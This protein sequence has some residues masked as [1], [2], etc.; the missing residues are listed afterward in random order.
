LDT[1]IRMT[2]A[3][4][5]HRDSLVLYKS[6]PGR[7]LSLGGKKLELEMGG[8][9]TLSV[10]PKDVVL[11]HRGPLGNLDELAPQSG[12]TETAWEL[13][14]GTTTNLAELAELAYGE[15]TPAS[16]WAAWQLVVEGL[17]FSGSPAKIEAHSREVVASEREDR[18]AKAAEEVAWRAFTERVGEGYF[19]PEDSSFLED[20][21]GLA[22]GEYEQSRVLRALG[23]E[24]SQ[25]VAHAL[26][27]GVGYWD[28]AINPYPSR[29]GLSTASPTAELP[30]LLDEE[31]IDLTHLTALAIDD[32]GSQDPDDALSFEDGRLWVHIA[33]AAALVPPGSPADV[34]ARSRGASLYLP[35]GTV[36]M[37][38]RLATQRLGLGLSE[39]SPA[40]S[41]SFSVDSGGVLSDLE[42]APG[43]IRV[44]RLTYEEADGQ[45]ET[46][47]LRELYNLSQIYEERRRRNGAIMIDMPEVKVWLSEG[48]VHIRPLPA[49]RSRALVRE[50]MLMAG[51]SLARYALEHEIPFAFSSQALPPDELPPANSLSEMYAL[52]R[53]LKPSR[54]SSRPGPH[55]GLGLE[56]YAQA[57]SPLRRYLDLVAHQQ[58]RAHLRGEKM[59]E[60]QAITERVGATSAVAGSVRWAERRSVE[61]WTLVYLRQHADWEG[62]GIVVEKRG[63]RA[64]IVVPD[65]GLEAA[66]FERRPLALDGKVRL[67]LNGVNLPE[68]E[69]YF[70][71]AG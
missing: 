29:A 43:W 40:L 25:Q 57:T 37:L 41:L 47:P 38:P 1:I 69:A 58:L 62:E 48:Q 70:R 32:E 34:E 51:E 54:R 56:I 4:K 19:L 55:A 16:A 45:L 10:R 71:F 39:I 65:L 22:R 23:Q 46:E 13:L 3:S 28:Q 17:Y 24:E 59:L 61:H 63:H 50:A 27:L 42:L 64:V 12:E 31:R 67:A 5:L 8:G 36:T 52:R 6:R 30:E 53:S 33:D 15:F 60:V 49:L 7:V 18:E 2:P 35:E 68:L 11:L 21:A 9:Q 44:S 26:L 14:A 66:I 20:V